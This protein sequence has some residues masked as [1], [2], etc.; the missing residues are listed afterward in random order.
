MSKVRPERFETC[1]IRALQTQE[2]VQYVSHY[3]TGGEVARVEDQK[4]WA[5]FGRSFVKRK[6]GQGGKESAP[7]RAPKRRRLKS[8]VTLMQIDNMLRGNAD[9]CLADFHIAPGPTGCLPDPF[10]WPSLNLSPDSGPDM[11]CLAH[12]LAYA[13][14]LNINADFDLCHSSSNSAKNALKRSKLWTH[15]VLMSAAA[16]CVYGSTL[17]PPRLQQIRECVEEFFETSTP[18]DPY[19]Q[20]YLPLLVDQLRLG[21]QLTDLGADKV[22]R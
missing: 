13:K 11:V 1:P 4:R 6:L 22:A 16:N 5:A 21:V 8:Y 18:D 14:G 3:Q 19:F 17:S 20:S 10:T 7:P 2:C 15:Q 9:K 12:F